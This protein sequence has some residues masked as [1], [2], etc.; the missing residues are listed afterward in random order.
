MGFVEKE[1]PSKQGF[2]GSGITVDKLRN[3]VAALQDP[4]RMR[5][6]RSPLLGPDTQELP[7]SRDAKRVFEK[8]AAVSLCPP[9][10][11][12]HVSWRMHA[13]ACLSSKVLW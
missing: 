4:E 1:T 5:E 11:N 13:I 8:A 12:F 7:F 2:Y 9:S 10:L 6:P 3:A